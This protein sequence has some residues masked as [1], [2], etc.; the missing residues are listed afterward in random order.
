[1]NQETTAQDIAEP[2]LTG[3]LQ[4]LKQRGVELTSSGGALRFRAPEGV[5]TSELKTRIRA[6]R[7]QLLALLSNTPAPGTGIPASDGSFPT[8]DIQAA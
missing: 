2:A 1:M 7:D 5:M 8:T 4:D 6:H 3:L